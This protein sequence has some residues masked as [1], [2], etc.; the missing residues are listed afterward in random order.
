MRQ[1]RAVRGTRRLLRFFAAVAI[2]V[3]TATV[4]AVAA[5]ADPARP[6]NFESTVLSTQPELPAGIDLAIVGGDAFLRLHV[7]EGLEVIVPDYTQGPGTTPPPDLR[8]EADGTV[9]VNEASAAAVINDAR[10]G[11]A[12]ASIDIDQPPRWKTVASDGTY[13]WHDHRVHWMTPTDPP[14]M[15]GSRRI[16]MGG[17]EGTWEVDLIVDGVPTLVTGELLLLRAPSPVPWMGLGALV[18]AAIGVFGVVRV[19]TTGRAPHQA[20]AAILVAVGV[21]AAVVGWAEWHDVPAGGGGSPFTA[22]IPAVGAVT[23]AIAVAVSA[24]RVRLVALLA[25]VACVGAWAWMRRIV[26]ARAVLP[27]TLPFPMDRLVT[28][29]ALGLAVGVAAIVVWR[30]PVASRPQR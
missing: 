28:V 9:S 29:V 21:A 27:T 12:G 2:A 10:Y 4:P 15:A 7:D 17:D 11:R 22:I 14:T 8:F 19:R 24:A 18:A 1:G 30:P 23:A 16:D 13:A 26:V 5:Q 3:G 25:A 20:L 6:T